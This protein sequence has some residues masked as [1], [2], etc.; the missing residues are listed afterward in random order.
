MAI[1]IIGLGGALTD[2]SSSLWA[3]KEA[4]EGAKEAGAEVKL[5][6]I[7]EMNLP[8]LDLRN[9]QVPDVIKELCKDIDE[10]DAMIW[11]SPLYHGTI[12]GSF[13]NA[14]DWLEE[15]RGNTPAYLTNKFIGL[16]STAGGSQGL[17]AINTMEYAVRALR[18]FTVPLVV[19]IAQSSKV[20]DAKGNISDENVK[21]QL[22]N[23]S[24]EVIRA[25]TSFQ[26]GI[27]I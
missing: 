8:M 9:Y 20:F 13:K 11:S 21:A 2:E 1:K 27:T 23:L 5:Y 12:S 14:L 25:A 15:L 7:G 3:L 10:A 19:P 22:H 4:L 6:S 26:A 17:Q 18:G 16:I 24:K